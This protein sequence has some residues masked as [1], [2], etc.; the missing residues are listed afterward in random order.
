MMK[1]LFAA[2][3]VIAGVVL[4]LYP[5]GASLNGKDKLNAAIHDYLMSNP[6][7]I[8]EALQKFQ[9]EQQVAEAEKA[10]QNL[11]DSSK[12]LYEDPTTA[13]IGPKD[14][15]ISVVEFFDYNCGVCKMTF[16][17]M[18]QL[19]AE[20]PKVRVLF[21][22]FPIFGPTSEMNS[23]I[24]LSVW[25]LAPDKYFDFHSHMMEAKG[26]PD[27]AAV[28]E[29]VKAAGVD[30]DA[31][32]ETMKSDDI[33]KALEA[34]RALGAKL[35]VRGT[36][37]VVIGDFLSPGALSLEE[38]KLHIQAARDLASGKS[39]KKADAESPTPTADVTPPPSGQPA[40]T[41]EAPGTPAPLP[42]AE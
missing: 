31:V 36:P 8:I 3:A 23:R 21:K 25:K 26:H 12:E 13:F 17:T 42:N 28:W 9:M 27:E 32:K 37:A 16:G 10:K 1:Y 7:V 19:L 41:A 34:S 5:Q 11:R 22:E 14:A 33:T 18:K 24:G 15:D 2:I 40:G 4:Y 39:K 38:L 6:Q 35:G 30:V 20:D 29:M